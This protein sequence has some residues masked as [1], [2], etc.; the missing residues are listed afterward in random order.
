VKL[1]TRGVVRIALIAALYV[2]LT[3]G[4]A[5]LAYGP[6]QFR[7]AEALKAIVVFNP[8]LAIGIGIGTFFANMIS[9]FVGPWE[10][11][12]MPLTDLAGGLIAWQL[13]KRSQVAAMLVYALTTAGAV[14]AM[15][16]AMGVGSFWALFFAIAVSET[17]LLLG[18]LPLFNYVEKILQARGISLRDS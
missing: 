14:T 1:S 2:V 4:I 9:P 17:V 13:G 8:V 6:I 16:V 12:W 18:G 15:L 3:V 7:V 10:L 5:P 11:I